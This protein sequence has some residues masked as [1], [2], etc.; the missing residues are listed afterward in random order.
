MGLNTE[1]YNK[2]GN[3]ALKIEGAFMMATNK[4]KT[5][6]KVLR[7]IVFLLL[8]VLVLFGFFLAFAGITEFRPGKR[9]E[10]PVHSVPD[11]LNANTVFSLLNWNIGYAGLGGNMDFFYDGGESVRDTRENVSDNMKAIRE[12]IVANDSCDF[13]LLQE[14]DLRSKR[15][16]NMDQLDELRK[17]LPGFQAYEG[18]NYKV[19]FVPVPLSS[20]MGRVLSG[21]VIFS[22]PQ[23]AASVRYAFEGNYSWPTSLFMLKRCYLVN[24]YPIENGKEFILVNTHNSAYDDGSLRAAQLSQLEAFVLEESGKGNPVVISGDWNQSPAGY[25]APGTFPF[26]TINVSWLPD[27]FLPGWQQVYVDSVPTNRR[28]TQPYH[29]GITPSTVIDFFVVSPDIQVLGI[30]AVD[31]KF[32]HSDHN[33]VY[34]TF[35]LQNN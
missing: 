16:Y 32:R 30:K 33:P 1:N 6:R 24:R 21:V 26:D 31:L 22:N 8:V 35:K 2:F 23:P 17:A 3:I 25:Q 11:T 18:I 7:G 10:N 4:N 14:V 29:E 15:S 28:V 27:G 34:L 12:Y 5:F 19:N 20:P 9:V 13:I